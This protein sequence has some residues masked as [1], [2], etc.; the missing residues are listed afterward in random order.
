MP[1]L[2]PSQAPGTPLVELQHPSRVVVIGANGSGK[3]R[4][5]IWLEENNQETIPVHRISAQKALSLPDYA[6][7]LNLEQAEKALHFGRSDE[8]ANVSRKNADRWG[9]K[10]ATHLLSDYDKLLSLLFARESARDRKHTQ[11][12]KAAQEY[13]PVPDSPIDTIVKLWGYLMPHRSI[14]FLDGKVLVGKGTADEYH[15][16]EMSDGE[17]VTLY[18]LGQCLTAP[19]GSMIIIDEPELH[20]HRSLMDKLWNKVEEL[21]PDKTIVY[22]THDL[23]FAASRA[24]AKKLW[25][26]SYSNNAWIWRDLPTDEAL[27]EALVLEIVG[28][29]KPILFCEGERG[30]LDHTI[31]QLCYPNH[32]IMPRGGSEKVVEAVKALNANAVLHTVAATGLVDKDVRTAEEIQAL[33]SQRVRVLP[34]AEVEN[35]LCNKSMVKAAATAL[36]LDP[37]STVT[38]VTEYVARSL[39]EELEAQVV[40][41]A[42]RRIRYHLGCYSPVA[43][44]KPGVLTGVTNLIASLD[45]AAILS[46][47]EAILQGAISSGDL[48]TILGVYNRKSLADRIAV[49]FGLKPGGYK[50]LILRL[51]RGDRAVHFVPMIQQHLPAL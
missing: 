5:G 31:Y 28:S 27:P 35:L 29:R 30:G 10:P 21:S 1:V 3:T 8:H 39:A 47:S 36:E 33:E 12:T 41:H 16:K 13:I 20:L 17:R 19:V 42:A 46:Q 49:C 4:L 18:L 22:I 34:F 43:N 48:N 7:V 11:D 14:S 9:S 6:P 2:L 23:D 24:G 40:L 44:D 45:V 50:D 51:L 25:I 37:D 26:Q 32:H 38:A 15:A